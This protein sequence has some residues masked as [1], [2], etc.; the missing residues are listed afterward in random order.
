MDPLPPDPVVSLIYRAKHGEGCQSECQN[1][2][3]RGCSHTRPRPHPDDFRAVMAGTHTL[4]REGYMAVTLL[5]RDFRPSVRTPAAPAMSPWH[6]RERKRGREG[7]GGGERQEEREGERE[8]QGEREGEGES[9]RDRERGRERERKSGR[10]ERSTTR[11]S[12][13][14]CDPP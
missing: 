5:P 2:I 8:R 4:P 10:E 6:E 9:E 3:P 1:V 12:R 14:A 13:N 11:C 7:G